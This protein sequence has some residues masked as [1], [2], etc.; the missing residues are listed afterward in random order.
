MRAVRRLLA[1]SPAVSEHVARSARSTGHLGAADLAR[2]VVGVVLRVAELQGGQAQ[3][4]RAAMARA[5]ELVDRRAV[6]PRPP[7][8][9]VGPERSLMPH[10]RDF[11]ARARAFPRQRAELLDAVLA[12]L[13]ENPP[14]TPWRLGPDERAWVYLRAWTTA[15]ALDDRPEPTPNQEDPT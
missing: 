9:G 2:Y 15:L 13:F 1:E 11:V 3:V 5:A 10:D 12:D 6:E 8:F 4:G 14:A 7:P